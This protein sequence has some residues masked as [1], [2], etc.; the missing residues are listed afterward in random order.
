MVSDD[1]KSKLYVSAD[2]VIQLSAHQIVECSSK[3]RKKNKISELVPEINNPNL[4]LLIMLN[5][6]R[7]KNYTSTLKKKV[8]IYIN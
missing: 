3:D 8:I 4:I 1:I 2:I 7:T 6:T 5:I